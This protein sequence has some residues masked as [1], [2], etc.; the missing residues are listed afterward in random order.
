LFEREPG[1]PPRE[2][3]EPGD[4]PPEQSS[5][6]RE[7]GVGPPDP[8]VTRTVVRP[9]V[10]VFVQAYDPRTERIVWLVTAVVDVVL[11]MRFIFMLLGASTQAAFASLLYGLTLPL[12]APFQGMFNTPSRGG[13]VFEPASIVAIIVYTLIGWVIVAT[14]RIRHSRR[15]PPP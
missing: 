10:P 14:I 11:A 12:V 5:V 13:S 1:Y 15:R 6:V 9:G 4:L 2:P 8:N 7:P 3:V